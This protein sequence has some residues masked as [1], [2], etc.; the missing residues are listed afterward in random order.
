MYIIK[1]I[2]SFFSHTFRE[3]LT[4]IRYFSELLINKLNSF[5]SYGYPLNDDIFDLLSNSWWFIDI[6]NA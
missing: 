4:Y 6:F 1:L 2:I 3:R 5:D